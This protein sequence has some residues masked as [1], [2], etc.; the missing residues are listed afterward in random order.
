MDFS[1]V[2]RHTKQLITHELP[3]ILT[4]AVNALKNSNIPSNTDELSKLNTATLLTLAPRLMCVFVAFAIPLCWLYNSRED[5]MIAE[6][7]D[8]KRWKTSKA[9]NSVT[10]STTTSSTFLF[11]Q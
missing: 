2:L 4:S 10:S 5:I 6:I 7:A 1:F 8:Q 11:T 9:K 3:S